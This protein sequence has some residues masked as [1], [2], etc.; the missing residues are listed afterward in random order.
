MKLVFPTWHASCAYR[1]KGTLD[2]QIDD[3]RRGV[4]RP[5]ALAGVP[6]DVRILDGLGGW[7][8]RVDE[9]DA[10]AHV[11]VEHAGTVV[12]VGVRRVVLHR[13][14]DQ[15]GQSEPTQLSERLAFR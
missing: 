1:T 9:V 8:A 4:A 13:A 7:V 14:R 2:I 5:P 12:P 15:I 11:L 10:H 6:V 3:H